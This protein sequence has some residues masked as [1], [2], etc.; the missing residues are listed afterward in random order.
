MFTSSEQRRIH[1]FRKELNRLDRLS[2][3][4]TD[5]LWHGTHGTHNQEKYNQI[6]ARFNRTGQQYRNVYRKQLEYANALK[7]KYGLRVYSMGRPNLNRVER[8][9]KLNT[10]RRSTQKIFRTTPLP[11]N[12]FRVIFPNRPRSGMYRNVEPW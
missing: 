10:A 2:L 6:R 5:R 1:A 12:V 11:P 4:L 3:N 9:L 7:R 8:A